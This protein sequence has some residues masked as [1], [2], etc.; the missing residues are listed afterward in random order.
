[1]GFP[2]RRIS[3]C[4]LA[5]ELLPTIKLTFPVLPI[6][7]IRCPALTHSPSFTCNF[8][9]CAYALKNF[10]LCLTII[11][12]PYLTSPL[13]AY[14]TRP[15][16]DATIALPR[17]P[18]KSSPWRDGSFAKNVLNIRRCLT[19]QCHLSG[20]D[21]C[22]VTCGLKTLFIAVFAAAITVLAL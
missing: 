9:L 19:G 18:A 13:H 22:G 8:R 6:S 21:C 16:A 11:S 20:P 2:F 14:T 12:W 4:S 7:A 1:M 15:E 10:S 17:P 3:K 5:C